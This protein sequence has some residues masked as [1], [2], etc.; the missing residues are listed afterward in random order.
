MWLERQANKQEVSITVDEKIYT[1]KL[2]KLTCANGMLYSIP[3]NNTN[4][5]VQY[6]LQ[7]TAQY[8]IESEEF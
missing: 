2:I 1:G 3:D 6:Q 7:I 5:G 4:S 8:T